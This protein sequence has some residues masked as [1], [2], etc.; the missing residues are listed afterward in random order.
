MAKAVLALL[1]VVAT[2]CIAGGYFYVHPTAL[3]TSFSGRY[4]LDSINVGPVSHLPS[5]QGLSL[6]D[7]PHLLQE[8]QGSPV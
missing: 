7:Q 5:A 4:L 8:L 3:P 1:A 6:T 2:A